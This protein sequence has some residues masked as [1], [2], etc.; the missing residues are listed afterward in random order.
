M[1]TNTALAVNWGIVKSW[2]EESRY[3]ISGLNGR[4][5]NNAVMHQMEC[6]MINNVGKRSDTQGH[7]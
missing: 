5:L 6:C 3:R 4:D 7:V 1:K 2:S